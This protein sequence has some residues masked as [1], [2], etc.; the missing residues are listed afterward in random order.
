MGKLD[1]VHVAIAPPD[2]LEA[3]LAEKV[4][5]IVNKNLSRT[6]LLLVGKIPRI[7]AQYQTIEKAESIAQSLRYM[8]LV[9][10]VC[11]DAE[12]RKSFSKRFRAHS[13]K[14]GEGEIIFRDNDG[15][16]RSLKEKDVFL[17][18]KGT[19]QTCT[20]KESTKTRMKFSLP[21][22]VLTGGFPVWRKVKEKTKNVS[23]ESECFVRLYERMSLEPSV[24][25]FQYS[26][27]YSFLGAKMTFSSP[28]NLGN[29]ITEL[30]NA[31]PQAVFDD[32]LTKSFGVDIP[33]VPS[34]DSIEINCKLIYLYHRAV[35]NLSPSA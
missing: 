16:G 23:V 2:T 4:A 18:L 25:I 24:E 19:M 14:Q 34:E 27:D 1:I 3:G 29:T 9:A 8:G 26:F 21:G 17:I 35:N 12:L 15:V 22:T 30:R 11:S 32:R 13:L 6:R 31:F 20:E 33:F 10:L 5:A 7:I 28:I